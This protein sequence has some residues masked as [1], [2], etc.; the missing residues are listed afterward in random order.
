MHV[1]SG[2]D[3]LVGWLVGR[4]VGLLFCL[5]LG[6]WCAP[7]WL[8]LLMGWQCFA[9][10]RRLA[11]AT[12]THMQTTGSTHRREVRVALPHKQARAV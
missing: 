12:P 3:E 2:L 7:V 4:L 8:L 10:G 11:S 6:G 9:P 1:R 5:V